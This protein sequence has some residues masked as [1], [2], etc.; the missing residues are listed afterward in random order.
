[1]CQLLSGFV[2]WESST[3]DF[4]TKS[5]ITVHVFFQKIESINLFM[6]DKNKYISIYIQ[7]EIFLHSHFICRIFTEMK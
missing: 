7:Y 5:P 2:P 1:M 3:L 4:L 6:R